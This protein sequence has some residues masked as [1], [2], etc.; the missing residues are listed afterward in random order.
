MGGDLERAASGRHSRTRPTGARTPRSFP[1]CTGKTCLA[2]LHPQRR[3]AIDAARDHRPTRPEQFGPPG[4]SYIFLQCSKN[5]I[6]HFFRRSSTHPL[7]EVIFPCS[8]L[9]SVWVLAHVFLL[10]QT[11]LK[12]LRFAARLH[13]ILHKIKLQCDLWNYRRVLFE[14]QSRNTLQIM[15]YFLKSI[16]PCSSHLSWKSNHYTLKMQNSYY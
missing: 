2:R 8:A 6:G 11:V 10:L 13:Y 14:N 4:C 5:C 1:R 9:G 3:L 16:L 7:A 15:L 12:H